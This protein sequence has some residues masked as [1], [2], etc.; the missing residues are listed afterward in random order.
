MLRIHFLQQ[1]VNLSDPGTEEAPRAIARRWLGGSARIEL[2][3]FFE[4]LHPL[5]HLLHQAPRLADDR[6]AVLYRRRQG[7]FSVESVSTGFM[8]GSL[9]A[10]EAGSGR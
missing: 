1:W 8:L 10:R 6:M 7:R 9:L 3:L 2:D 4:Y 5:P